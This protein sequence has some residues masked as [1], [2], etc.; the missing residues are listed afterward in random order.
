MVAP[1]EESRTT[2]V[3]LPSPTLRLQSQGI[4]TSNGRK[5]GKQ[6]SLSCDV[7]EA[8]GKVIHSK[9]KQHVFTHG[10]HRLQHFSY[11]SPVRYM[12]YSESTAVFISLH[13][14]NTVCL[15]KLDGHKRTSLLHSTRF[16]F[17]GLTATK[18]SGCL[19]GWGPGPVF[20]FLD[21][22]LQPLEAAHDALDIRMCQAAEHSTELVTAGVGN[23]CVWSA[24]LMRCKMKITEGLE[25]R[26]FTQ[27][28][29]AAPRSDR[30]HRA[31]V[32]S[33]RV[34]TVVDLKAGKVLEH[35]KDLCSRD[36]TA[37]AY[38]SHLDYLI[39]ASQELSIRVWGPNWELRV[40]F[41]GHNG[42]VNS[43]FYCSELHMLLSASVDCTIRCW[44]L[45]E[46]DVVECVHTEQKTPPLCIGG[47]RKGDTFFSFS[48]QGVDFWA[49]R[50]LYTLHCK[51]GGD[52]RVALRQILVSP[53]PAPF[54]TR[55]LCVSG[56]SDIT[57]VAAETG[58]VLTS[59]KAEQR[60]LCA[61]YC[62][63]KEILLAL[64]EA[65]TV[66][67]ANTLTNPITL[68]QE[69]Q[70]RGQGPWQMRDH[71]TENDAQNLPIPG[72]ACCLALYSYVAETQGALEDWSNL[73][74]RRGCSQRNKA[75]L[76]DAKNKFLIML[77]Q[78]G[79][80][81]SVLKLD[82]GKVLYRTPAHS[83]QRVTALQAYP[84]NGCLLSSGE[85]M[86]VVVWRVNPYVQECLSIQ[87]S[88][89][90][91]QPQIYL[92]VLGP[93][94]ALTFQEPSSGTYSL[95]HINLL[96][97]RRTDHPPREGHLDHF[98]GL[99]VCPDLEVFVS[100]SLDG[101]VRIWNKENR[102]IRTFQLNAV[103][104]CV[105]YSGFRG[106]MFLA[107]G[108]DLYR[109]ICANFLPHNYQQMILYTY[110]AEPIPDFPILKNIDAN[111]TAS[112]AKDEEEE[113]I[114]SNRLMTEDVC[115][116]K[117][118]EGLVTSNMDLTALLLGTVKCKK[119]K[120]ASTKETRREAFDHYMKII[121]RLPANIKIELEDTF[122]PNKLSFY[123]EPYEKKPYKPP[124]KPPSRPPSK[125]PSEP[126]T[127][128][129]V[130]RPKL[131]IPVNVEKKK[132]EEKMAPVVNSKPKTPV[133]VKPQ[134]VILVDKVI[135]EKPVIVEKEEEPQEIIP[136]KEQPKPT[137][138]PPT[139]PA[140]P[141][142]PARP[143]PPAHT[144]EV[145]A[146][147]K[148]FTDAGWFKD[149][150]PD[151]KSIPSSLSPE[152][153]SLKLLRYL[154]TCSA[155]SKI[156]ILAA[157]QALH[158]QGLIP[159]TDQLYQDLIDLVPKL[160]RPNM[161]AGER[162]TLYEILNLLMR[163]KSANYNLMIKL[164]TLLAYKKLRL[165]ETILRMLTAL[166][167]D[168]AEEWLWPELE[169]W[170]SELQKQSDIWKSLHGRAD[171]W[172][173]LWITKYKGHNKHLFLKSTAKSKPPA[174]TV[175]EVLNY[176]CSVQKEEYKKA[177]YVA[178]TGQKNTVLLPLYD[179]S[180][181]ILRLGETYSMARIRRP[182]GIILPPLRSRPFLM[183]FPNF[184][185]LPLPRVTLSPFHISSDED[186][187]KASP[188]RYF[189]QQQ[190][191]VD[192]Y[193]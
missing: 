161:S 110:N 148:Q 78:S 112:R 40:A 170:D 95:T 186:W 130:V 31:F 118:D 11:D 60:I 122:D 177:Q 71:V 83:G 103:P 29:L 178:P 125:P 169:S 128:E 157:L 142:P 115:R 163:L 88:L 34:V 174:F 27:M 131:N 26:T 137:L 36:I 82:N 76:D 13:S 90:C 62:L 84:E 53:F 180:Q 141:A 86:T 107:I 155:P 18:V 4:R 22:D 152:D 89:H 64:T 85:D 47:S 61:D 140:R 153:F 48:H 132:C 191:Y 54:P 166:G 165:R 167:V 67:Q 57:L 56:D 35:K 160:A 120:P 81:V 92:A 176:F 159:N 50:S 9:S 99:C 25:N 39:I 173:E 23:V 189:I 33:G 63:H 102:L 164:L 49:I 69:W 72:L 145:P 2:T 150:Y 116:Q 93:Q 181:P 38:C 158:S 182:P 20:T 66:L 94:L 100:S 104:E 156:K 55:V 109:M 30:P 80:C 87:L 105:A 75:A 68:M 124:S 28:A 111:R 77:G 113:A 32:V 14:D 144:P 146:F 74:E 58:A 15:Y 98:T 91:G 171:C 175:V 168:E 51:L 44:D 16:S 37:M 17:M 3:L 21:K 135:P 1:G 7:K 101:T 59:F 46:G 139:P 96:N 190:S 106:E 123:P 5:L 193:R 184:I 42:V 151:N 138:K 185:S 187:L 97:Q 136:P 6:N 147:L 179:C 129:K 24:M 188:H 126:P 114:A 65:G 133:K 119:E 43:L 121:Y 149:L 19:V 73:Q 192:Y 183:H 134:P 12:M 45:E 52:K 10:L 127:L 41:V 79:G 70:G 162:A 8:T 108:G 117:Q 172:L 143:T 154:N